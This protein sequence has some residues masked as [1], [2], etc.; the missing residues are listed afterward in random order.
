MIEGFISLIAHLVPEGTPYVLM[1]F[2]VLIER[3]SILIRPITLSVRLGA[4]IIAGHLLLALIGGVANITK[5]SS[6]VGAFVGL[7]PLLV[8]ESAVAIIQAYVLTVLV[9]LYIMEV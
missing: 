5:I 9:T 6:I 1:P 3:V 7:T 8:L 4:N 2:I